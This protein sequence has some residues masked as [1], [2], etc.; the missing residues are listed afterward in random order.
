MKSV[1]LLGRILFSAIFIESAI[2]HFSAQTIAYAAGN[3]VPIADIV[4]PFS[5]IL[6][7]IGGISVLIGYKARWGAWMLVAFLVPVTLMMHDFWNM[8]DPQASMNRVMF[9]KNISMLG[10]AL[11]IAYFGAGP[12]SFD[13]SRLV[14]PTVKE[15]QAMW[16]PPT[17]PNGIR[18]EPERKPVG[19]F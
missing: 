9:M 16:A 14:S 17:Q 6:A 2:G 12:V 8:T 13:H 18:K 7:L 15:P 3:G 10:G 19:I 5:G 11:L 1:V 4:V